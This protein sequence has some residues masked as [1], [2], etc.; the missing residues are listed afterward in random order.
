MGRLPRA[1]TIAAIAE[2]VGV[3]AATVSKVLNGRAD[4]AKETRIRVEASLERHQY[5]RRPRRLVTTAC[6]AAGRSACCWSCAACSQPSSGNC[7]SGRSRS[8]SW[9]PTARPRRWCR[10]EVPGQVSV[11][12]YDN[13]PV[14]AWTDPALTTVNQ[15]LRDMAGAATRML[16]DLAR[17]IEPVS[18]RIDLV[19]GLVVRESTAAPPNWAATA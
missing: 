17:G 4:V 5:Q 18:T 11:I 19:T 3:S 8:S 10:L 14:A 13:L 15:P 6:S 9:T 7:V 1:A 16:L 12:G 2:D